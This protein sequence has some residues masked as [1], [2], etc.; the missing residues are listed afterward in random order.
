[1]SV[2]VVFSGLMNCIA[3][4][5]IKKPIDLA[6]VFD[7]LKLRNNALLEQIKKTEKEYSDLSSEYHSA[8]DRYQQNNYNHQK[9]LEEKRKQLQDLFMEKQDVIVAKEI[10]EGDFNRMKEKVQSLEQEKKALNEEIKNFGAT[11]DEEFYQNQAVLHGMRIKKKETEIQELTQKN[12]RLS[13][14]NLKLLEK[15]NIS[16]KLL[17]RTK[18]ESK[19][20]I[21][22]LEKQ[23][24]EQADDIAKK[25]AELSYLRYANE[26]KSSQMDKLQKDV[27][28]LL[29]KL[30]ESNKLHK[31]LQHDS[32]I[33]HI[34]SKN[35][36][37]VCFLRFCVLFHVW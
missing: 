13:E 33:A 29:V 21:D 34:L 20:R 36:Y 19:Y 26:Q 10:I 15:S 12:K 9:Y 17:E 31:S 11:I 37:E 16:E 3:H 24:L 28:D 1:M 27:E 7:E 35:D 32:K 4:P 14:E 22:S 30:Q 25:N 8:K 6:D 2:I 18:D 5:K 23:N